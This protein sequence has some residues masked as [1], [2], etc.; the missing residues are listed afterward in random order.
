MSNGLLLASSCMQSFCSVV[1]I[2]PK[3]STKN[4]CLFIIGL[5]QQDLADDRSR[6]NS[7]CAA[8]PV[9]KLLQLLFT[10]IL[11]SQCA[12]H[13][14]HC[15]ATCPSSCQPCPAYHQPETC[16]N[17]RKRQEAVN[18]LFTRLSGSYWKSLEFPS[19]LSALCH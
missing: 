12:A 10:Y 7:V 1:E 8:D 6:C 16:Q 4:R 14:T 11:N 2:T 19:L 13:P 9:R 15:Y 5:S 3:W 17:G 18:F